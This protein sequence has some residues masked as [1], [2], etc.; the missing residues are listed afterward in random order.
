MRTSKACFF[1]RRRCWTDA[2]F[3][4]SSLLVSYG[5]LNCNLLL[6][7][8]C[9]RFARSRN[10]SFS[11]CVS[12]FTTTHIECRIEHMWPDGLLY[13]ALRASKSFLQKPNRDG[14]QLDQLEKGSDP[15]PL[16]WH[17]SV[18]RR[19]GQTAFRALLSIS[20]WTNLQNIFSV[21]GPSSTLSSQS[22]GG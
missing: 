20:S 16:T 2:I 14:C 22:R 19:W 18:S 8:V 12:R 10:L 4:P 5:S 11:K 13:V 15:P 3:T 1:P 21:N 9:L 7:F 17:A 6:C